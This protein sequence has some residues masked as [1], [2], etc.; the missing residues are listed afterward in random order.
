MINI[1]SVAG[2][3]PRPG[4]FFRKPPADRPHLGSDLWHDTGRS[5]ADPWDFGFGRIPPFVAYE[6]GSADRL[7]MTF[8]TEATNL[9]SLVDF[10][11]P[12]AYQSVNA[13]GNA[14]PGACP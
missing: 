6:L 13:T 7:E 12:I 2:P 5:S 3:I 8:Q 11:A 10:T 4:R 1:N 9:G 14:N